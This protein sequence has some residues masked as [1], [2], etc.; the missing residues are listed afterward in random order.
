MDGLVSGSER[1]RCEFLGRFILIHYWVKVIGVKAN[2]VN[3]S[4]TKLRIVLTNEISS[5]GRQNTIVVEMNNNV[6]AFENNQKK[7]KKHLSHNKPQ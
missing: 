2:A 7:K 4:I 6:P 3:K 1:K 5:F